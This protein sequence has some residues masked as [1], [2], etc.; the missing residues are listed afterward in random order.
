MTNYIYLFQEIY[1]M[2]RGQAA[3]EYL[4]LIGVLLA[5]LIPLFYYVS[6]YSGQNIKVEKTEDAVRVLGRAADSLYALGP[7]NKDFVW[8]TLPGSITEVNISG[9]QILIKTLVY[10]GL[11]DFY[12]TTIG[13]VN[14]SLP[15]QRGTYKILLEVS[16]SGVVQIEKS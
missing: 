8:I 6:N 2:K 15:T 4:V 12:Y 14:G 1:I 3:F 9:N 5:I 13:P 7:G 10:G 16:D 11:S